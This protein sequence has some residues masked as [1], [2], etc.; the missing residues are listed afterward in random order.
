M[1][2]ISNDDGD[3]FGARALLKAAKQLG[4]AYAIVPNRQRSA[5]SRALTLHKPLRVH[6]AGNGLYTLNGTPADC[7]VF[8]LFSGEFEKP[9][10]ILSGINWGNNCGLGPIIG[11]GT[12]GACWMAALEGIP[13]IAFSL[14]KT[15]HDWRKNE[16]WGNEQHLI[17]AVLRV[18]K[19]LKPKLGTDKFF[20][21]NLPENPLDAEIFYTNRLQRKNYRTVVEKRHD[22]N[23]V[24][25][26]WTS[27]IHTPPEE[28]TDLHEVMVRN[29]IAISE[30]SLWVSR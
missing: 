26:F 27:G 24:P 10:L 21:V 28:E 17:D 8:S 5:V 30:I 12:V 3:S 6:D 7:I 9:D 4:K 1:I 25:Y 16:N 23:N 20:N 14:Q 29:R 15:G 13:S 22:P 19:E 18:V 11:S 2:L